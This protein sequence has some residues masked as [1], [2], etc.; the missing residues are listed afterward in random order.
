MVNFITG[1]NTSDIRIKKIHMAWITIKLKLW[2]FGEVNIVNTRM[3]M[4]Q[5]NEAVLM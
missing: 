4:G 2:G 3:K 1:S 5:K